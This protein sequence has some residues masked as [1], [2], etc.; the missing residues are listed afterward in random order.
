ML[1]MPPEW[2]E[3]EQKMVH[4]LIFMKIDGVKK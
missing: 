2:G 4:F 1:D 3:L